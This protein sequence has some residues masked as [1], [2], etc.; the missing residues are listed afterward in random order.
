MWKPASKDRGEKKSAEMLKWLVPL[1]KT[2][3]LQVQTMNKPKIL[4]V[5]RP[6]IPQSWLTFKCLL[7][8]LNDTSLELMTTVDHTWV[9]TP[10]QT[11][12]LN[13]CLRHQLLPLP[14]YVTIW[15]F[16]NLTNIFA[17]LLGGCLTSRL[18]FPAFNL[19]A[20]KYQCCCT[21]IR[22]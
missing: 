9:Y 20:V 1:V 3:C 7:S 21:G 11:K 10:H 19:I 18:F 2:K 13:S 12:S 8:L 15:F 4:K 22:V 14:F 5:R 16:F 6:L 17:L